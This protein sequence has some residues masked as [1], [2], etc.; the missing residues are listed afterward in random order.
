MRSIVILEDKRARLGRLDASAACCISRSCEGPE[1]TH[2]V[3]VG[4]GVVQC[5]HSL[6]TGEHE[7]RVMTLCYLSMTYV[8]LGYNP[9]Y[10]GECCDV[11]S[12]V[13]H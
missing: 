5:Y 7:P 6:T 3:G 1:A 8:R 4:Q 12:P 9:K 13:L 11:V 2:V 10:L